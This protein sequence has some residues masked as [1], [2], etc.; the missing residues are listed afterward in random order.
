MALINLENINFIYDDNLALKD[1]SLSIEKGECIGLEG[2][3]GS[4]KTTLIKI[5]NGILFA[6]SGKYVFD[7]KEINQKTMKNEALAK[8]IHQRIGFV[9]QNP[10]TQ[11]FCNS[12]RDEIEFGPRQLGLSEEEIKTRCDDVIEILGIENIQERA[13]YH[14][15]GGEKKKTA[16]ACILSM[17]PEVLVLDEPMNGLDR[18]SREKLFAFLMGWKSAG[19]TLIIASH[20]DTLL[21]KFADRIVTITENHTL[22]Q[23]QNG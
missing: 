15:S 23:E 3:N 6:S 16:L 21:N 14:L 19:K 4:G 22:E 1:I 12:V 11:L 13:P 8:E 2:D 5:I 10:D 9:F 18:K 7:G 20:D 17:N